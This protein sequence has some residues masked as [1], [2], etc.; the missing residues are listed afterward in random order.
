MSSCNLDN[1]RRQGEISEFKKKHNDYTKNTCQHEGQPAIMH[2][3]DW[4]S[5]GIGK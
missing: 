4:R 3:R 2:R 1:S 5:E